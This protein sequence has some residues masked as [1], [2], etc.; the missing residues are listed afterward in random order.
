M[1]LDDVHGF[2]IS[3]CFRQPV[4]VYEVLQIRENR[5]SVFVRVILYCLLSVRGKYYVM[6][7]LSFLLVTL[8]RVGIRQ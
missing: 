4:Q 6:S 7:T 1:T 5:V 8:E 2:K 3:E